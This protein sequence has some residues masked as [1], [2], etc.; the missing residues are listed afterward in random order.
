MIKNNMDKKRKDDFLW[1]ALA[2]LICLGVGA[3]GSI[4]T[5]PAISGW[6]ASLIKP[7]FNPPNWLFSPVWT[8]LFILM[9]VALFL[10]LRRPKNIQYRRQAVSL[11]IVQL[12]LNLLWS[13]FFFFLQNP[14]AAL[15][16]I[17]ILWMAILLSLIYG[18]KVNRA[19]LWLLLPYLLWVSFAS[20]L[21][22]SIWALN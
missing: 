16:E 20:F 7:S 8:T 14:G 18:A 5:A 13:F 19:V 21:N 9:G 4:F 17:A 3:L 12:F 1:F 22:Y 6:Y 11:F 10:I 15:V 2:L